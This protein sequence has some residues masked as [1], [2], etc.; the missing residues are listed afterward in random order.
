MNDPLAI[1]LHIHCRDLPGTVFGERTAVRIGIQEGKEVIDDVPAEGESITFIAQLR[2]RRKA[3]GAVD[4]GGP[5]VQGPTSQRFIYLCWGERLAA[6]GW[7]GFS[8]VKILLQPLTWQVVERAM[9]DSKPLEAHLSMT[10]AN[11]KLVC[12]SVGAD[13][14]EWRVQE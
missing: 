11:G 8:R 5:F 2:V 4:F 13:R 6:G 12:A 3:D 7:D 1:R 14:V 9:R 10:D